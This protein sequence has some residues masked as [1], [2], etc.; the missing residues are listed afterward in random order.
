MFRKKLDRESKQAVPDQ[1][2]L[3]VLGESVLALARVLAAVSAWS[4]QSIWRLHQY[5]VDKWFFH[6]PIWPLRVLCGPEPV[7]AV[8]QDGFGFRYGTQY[9]VR[10]LAITLAG[11]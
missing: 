3:V 1:V 2:F 11:Y 7:R 8:S 6:Q 5:G 4:G 9:G 10:L